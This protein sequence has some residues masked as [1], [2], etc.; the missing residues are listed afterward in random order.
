MSTTSFIFPGRWAEAAGLLL[1][2]V[3]MLARV[4]L[5]ADVGGFFPAQLAAVAAVVLLGLDG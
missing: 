5:R 2:P 3:L 4:L 1:G